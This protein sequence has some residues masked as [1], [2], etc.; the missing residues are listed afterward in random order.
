MIPIVTEIAKHFDSDHEEDNTIT[1]LATTHADDLNAWLY[2]V[3]MGSINET[4]YQINPGDT[5]VMFFC[6][7]RS[8][9]CI[10]A[11][12]ETSVAL[13]NSSIISQLTNTISTQNEEAT[14]SNRLCHQEIDRTINKEETKKDRT[15]KIHDS[16]INMIGHAS[17]KSSTDKGMQSQHRAP[18][19]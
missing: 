17:A 10:K 1:S 5:E 13:D 9:Q 6:K 7:E 15:K 4:R 2:G 16:I 18:V 12:A 14:E 8:A 19:F 11:V 3:N